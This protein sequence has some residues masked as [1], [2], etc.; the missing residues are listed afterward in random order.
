M[1]IFNET[2]RLRTRCGLNNR[3]GPSDASGSLARV[4]KSSGRPFIGRRKKDLV[5]ERIQNR[6]K[7]FL[8]VY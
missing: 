7:K 8:A 2:E 4:K 1:F 3:W 5:Y 6:I